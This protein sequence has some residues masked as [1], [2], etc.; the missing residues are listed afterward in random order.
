M[1]ENVNLQDSVGVTVTRAQNIDW[2]PYIIAV[3]VALCVIWF[4]KKVKR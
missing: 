1:L 3:T 2:V 4:I